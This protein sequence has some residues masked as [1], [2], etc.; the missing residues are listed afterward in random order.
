MQREIGG[1]K[2]RLVSG[3]RRSGNQF[4]GLQSG[5]N[6]PNNVEAK[7]AIGADP[8]ETGLWADGAKA[9]TSGTRRKC[10]TSKKKR[11]QKKNYVALG[12]ATNSQDHSRGYESEASTRETGFLRKLMKGRTTPYM[13]R[14]ERKKTHLEA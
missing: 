9:N 5:K 12:D 8:W 10:G 4:G 2:F 7:A 13:I 6:P 3:G 1:E 14:E 11:G